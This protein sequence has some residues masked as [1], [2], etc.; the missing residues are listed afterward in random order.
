MHSIMS[1]HAY[2]TIR[3]LAAE[4]SQRG[5]SLIG[6][7]EHGPEIPGTV[8][9]IYFRNL[10]DA[11]RLLSGVEILYG[12]EINI[13]SGGAV[14]LEERA[15]RALDYLA[16]GIHIFCYED[17]GAVKNTDNML[18]CMEHPKV[19]FISHPDDDRFPL[20][21]PALV[22]GA[23][24]RNTALEVNNSSLRKMG[25]RPGCLENYR[26]MIPL[27]LENEVPLVVNSDAHDPGAVGD[28]SL[29]RAL[30][31]EFGVDDRSIL[32]ADPARLKAFL[33]G[34]KNY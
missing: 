20:D 2:G 25:L 28:V 18:R 26:K 6:I 34:Q 9:P 31:E 22:R 10:A 33:C 32:N 11:P 24:E 7:T 1:G 13:L 4:A 19:R 5:L 29:A 23:K 14:S 8:D 15:I 17:E 12:C 21:Y 16:A 3:E 30:L 27:C